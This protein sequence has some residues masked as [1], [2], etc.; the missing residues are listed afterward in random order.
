MA[1]SVKLTQVRGVVAAGSPEETAG[2]VVGQYYVRSTCSEASVATIDNWN[3]SFFLFTNTGDTY[4]HVCTVG[5]LVLYLELAP[6]G[7][8]DYYRLITCL[9]FFD[10][11]E[12]AWTAANLIKS[13]LQGLVDD[14]ED[15]INNPDGPFAGTDVEV[16]SS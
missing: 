6:G 8:D 12:A 11:L 1:T 13:R 14:W 15:Y 3:N 7:A 4:E 16:Y 2:G 10:D 9:L 5:D